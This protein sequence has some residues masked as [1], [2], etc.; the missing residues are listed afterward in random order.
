MASHWLLSLVRTVVYRITLRLGP[1]RCRA[2]EVFY[3]SSSKI[4]KTHRLRLP[5][6]RPSLDGE[7]PFTDS[8]I[9]VIYRQPADV[10]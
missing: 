5:A 1:G 7:N 8:L 2:R 10:T 6:L 3:R 9:K 4:R